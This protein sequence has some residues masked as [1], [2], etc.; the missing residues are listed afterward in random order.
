MN[1]PRLSGTELIV[2]AVNK[3]RFPRRL[4][5]YRAIDRNT[6][7]CLK[8]AKFWFAKPS[9]FNDPLDCNLS[10][11]PQQNITKYKLFLKKIG[12]TFADIKKSVSKIRKNP[13]SLSNQLKIHM[14]NSLN[15]RGVFSLS[16]NKDNILMWSH[17]SDNHEGLV[18]EFDILDDPSFFETPIN[19]DYQKAISH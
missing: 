13:V 14:K 7:K 19:V 18:I 11:N 1:S 5:K 15:K 16:K 4:F 10:F 12:M 6:K 2:I 9:T 8:E 17:Y 3:G